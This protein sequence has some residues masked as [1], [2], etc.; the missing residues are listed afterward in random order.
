MSKDAHVK[1][2]FFSKE[3]TRAIR[4]DIKIMT[5]RPIKPQPEYC[6]MSMAGLIVSNN[7]IHISDGLIMA[8]HATVVKLPYQLGDVLYVPEA[9]KCHAIYGELGYEVEF[10]DGERV[11]LQFLDKSCAVKWAK[12]SNKPKKNWQSPYFMPREAA[13]LFLRI[14]D[15]RVERLQD[16]TGEDALKEGAVTQR[17]Y[18]MYEEV[19]ALERYARGKFEELWNCTLKG[20]DRMYY[21]WDKNPWVIVISFEKIAPNLLNIS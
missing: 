2:I 7:P 9:W 21:G 13:R 8:E 20:A 1:H 18:F 17:P 19:G 4:D 11:Q 5:R 6:Y 12:Y 3:L 15:I 10:R 16:I 14:T